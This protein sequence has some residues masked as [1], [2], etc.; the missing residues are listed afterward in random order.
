MHELKIPS[1]GG[2]R[3]FYAE[4]RTQLAALL[5]G[6]TDLIANTANMASLLYHSLPDVN[7]AGFYF[8]KGGELVLGPFHGKPACVRIAMG[9]GV[10]GSAAAARLSL[11]IE[12]VHDFPGHIAC[13]AASRSE[14]VVPLVRGGEVLGVLDLDSPWPGRFEEEDRDGCESLAEVLLESLGS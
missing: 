6:E 10:C 7:W 14:L 12:D 4:L 5:E 13:D 3:E 11:L 2:K 8:L 9:K 1:V